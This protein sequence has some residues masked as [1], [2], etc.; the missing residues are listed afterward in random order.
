MARNRAGVLPDDRASWFDGA[1][2]GWAWSDRRE[3]AP[4][5][6]SSELW[7][8]TRSR[9]GGILMHLGSQERYRSASRDRAIYLTSDGR[10]A[11]ASKFGGTFQGVRS[12]SRYND[13]AWHHVVSTTGP[14]GLKLYLDGQLVASDESLTTPD[15]ASGFWRLGGDDP[16]GLPERPAATWTNVTLDEVSTYTRALSTDEVAAHYAAARR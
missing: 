9:A 15:A 11:S 8:N 1:L 4:N 14:D 10:V 2:G 12:A 6:S 7:F 13:G 16:A 5:P 3:E